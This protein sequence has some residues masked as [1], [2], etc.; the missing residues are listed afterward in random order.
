ML[1]IESALWII[2]PSK[3]MILFSQKPPYFSYANDAFLMLNS[4]FTSEKLWRFSQNKVTSSL[5]FIQRPGNSPHNCNMVYLHFFF[6]PESNEEY[7]EQGKPDL[8]H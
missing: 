2:L 8:P 6:P 3:Y 4:T 5:T 7:L 1:L